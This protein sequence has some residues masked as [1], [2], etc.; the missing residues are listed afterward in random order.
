MA[1]KVAQN[2]GLVL[3]LTVAFLQACDSPLESNISECEPSPNGLL[4]GIYAATPETASIFRVRGYQGTPVIEIS[5][6]GNIM[7]K[8]MPSMWRDWSTN[9]DAS[10]ESVEGIVVTDAHDPQ[11]IIEVSKINGKNKKGLTFMGAEGCSRFD[12]VQ[13]RIP[14]KGWDQNAYLVF[15]NSVKEP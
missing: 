4:V 14:Y 12:S 11:L 3:L 2:L 5:K 6:R 7:M 10:L 9:A 8:E 1:V 15:E 13:L